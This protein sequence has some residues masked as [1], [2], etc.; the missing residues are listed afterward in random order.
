MNNVIKSFDELS[1]LTSSKRK[2]QI[3]KKESRDN[4]YKRL[5]EVQKKM[6]SE[7]MVGLKLFTSAELYNIPEKKKKTIHYNF[8]KAQQV[9]N[10]WK[11][12]IV[13]NYSTFLMEKH[14]VAPSII[15]LFNDHSHP[16]NNFDCRISFQDL[17]VT[18]T[19][20]INVLIAHKLLPLNFQEL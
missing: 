8:R 13:I 6:Y 4:T 11:Q 10:I 16:T 15:K 14:S 1:T 3:T 18:R 17:N 20:I 9:L 19:D 7:V 2:M 12:K 5:T